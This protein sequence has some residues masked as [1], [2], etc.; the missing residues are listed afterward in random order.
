MFIYN[1]ITFNYIFY[2]CLDMDPLTIP[3]TR[4]YM[5]FN[6]MY[7]DTPSNHFR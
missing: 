5:I 1:E 3:L 4:Y 6:K 2:N 7:R